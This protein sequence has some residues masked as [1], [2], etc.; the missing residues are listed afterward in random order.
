M[1]VGR[2]P[3]SG[4]TEE[5]LVDQ[6]Q[7]AASIHRSGGI[8]LGERYAGFSAKSWETASRRTYSRI[9]R[10]GETLHLSPPLG[11]KTSEI[12]FQS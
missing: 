7:R 10:S 5:L 4:N 8:P 2:L 3:D 11:L 12:I 9:D 6:L 1:A